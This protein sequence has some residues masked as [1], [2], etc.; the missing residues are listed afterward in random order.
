[1]SIADTVSSSAG[2][3][4]QEHADMLVLRRGT[5]R[6]GSRSTASAASPEKGTGH[7]L[8]IFDHEQF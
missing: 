8:Y 3:R 5:F 7:D 4:Y 1:M 2:N 6:M